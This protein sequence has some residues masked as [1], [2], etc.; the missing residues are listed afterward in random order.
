MTKNVQNCFISILCLADFKPRPVV[1][2][3][4]W[5]PAEEKAV[6]SPRSL[7]QASK[8]SSAGIVV[9]PFPGDAYIIGDVYEKSH[10]RREQTKSS[11]NETTAPKTYLDHID[12]LT[13]NGWPQLRYL[14]DWMRVTTAP[15]KWQLLSPEAKKERASRVKV[16]LLDFRADSVTR[17]DISTAAQLRDLPSDSPTAYDGLLSRLFVV[18]DLSRDLIETLGLNLDVDPMF[19][20]GQLSDYIW[21]NTRDP[22]IE[23]PEIDF[24]S[25]KRSYFHV[26][27]SP[28]RYFRAHKDLSLA[29]TEAGGFNVLR[30]ISRDAIWIPGADIPGS[31][32][33]LLRSKISFWVRPRKESSTDPVT[34]ILLVDP[35]I[36]A[37]FP[38]WGGHN[39][40][41]VCPSVAD[42]V[43]ARPHKNSIFEDI[44][45]H[46][47]SMSVEDLAI[48]AQ[49]P[50]MLFQKPLCVICAEW[51]T[52]LQ[53]TNT[54][55]TQLEWEIEDPYLRNV[56]ED[57]I[58]TLNKL[59]VWR[60][61]FPLYKTIVSEVLTKVVRR[62]EFPFATTN[63]LCILEKDFELILDKLDQLHNRAER[64]MSVVTAVMSIEESKKALGQNRSLARLTYLAVTFV[65]LSFVSSF[66]AMNE[67]VTRLGRTF[68]IYFAVAIPVTLLALIVVRFSDTLSNIA[69][70]L[71]QFSATKGQ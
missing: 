40:F 23:L 22:W 59:H 67:D 70:R 12:Q 48:V 2:A 66:F 20:R 56:E 14:G 53:Y 10:I 63:S 7:A 57:L 55:L 39:D 68:W 28:A 33:G 16:A 54:R 32:V 50:R 25:R 37:G 42:K 51:Q 21:Y 5:E 35:S 38:L 8:Q 47:Q 30:R 65:P 44:I 27:Y 19:F 45:Y 41:D 64:I 52:L 61:R 71:L 18:E 49:D 15:P 69:R 24:V 26:S 9:E 46:L 43:R 58:T 60:R 17:H 62:Q 34:A 13:D 6:A 36:T 11:G 1:T 29:R 31:E 3:L 4:N